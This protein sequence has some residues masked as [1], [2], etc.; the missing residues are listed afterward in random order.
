MKK[1]TFLKI[2]FFIKISTNLGGNF[3]NLGSNCLDIW[4]FFTK[5]F[6]IPKSKFSAFYE[7]NRLISGQP[8]P[9]SS[10]FSRPDAALR[11]KR[12]HCE[13]PFAF[14]SSMRVHVTS[15]SHAR[16]I[17]KTTTLHVLHNFLFI[18]FRFYTSTT[19]KKCV[20]LLFFYGER[21]SSKTK[22]YSLSSLD[23][24]VLRNS[25]PSF[26]RPLLTKLV[27]RN[28][29]DK[30]WKRANSQRARVKTAVVSSRERESL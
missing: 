28:N 9:A 22:F 21:K 25:T 24:M 23:I 30:D 1:K 4:H 26:V 15:L 5:L 2:N 12:N 20:I 14:P 17:S 16:N 29:R 7:H 19:W 6:G 27:S 8:Y 3:S 18:S 11:R 10:G 13:Q